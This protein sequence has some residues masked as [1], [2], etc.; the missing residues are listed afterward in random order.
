[1]KHQKEFCIIGPSY[2]FRGGIPHY[3]TLLYKNLKKRHSVSFYAFKR[4]YPKWLFPGK[5]DRD[6]SSIAIKDDSIENMLD[7][8]NP[9]TWLKAFQKVKQDDPNVLIFP[10]WVSFWTPQFWSISTLI[11]KFTSAKVLFICHNIVQHE[12]KLWDRLC[13]KLVLKNGDYFIVHSDEDLGNLKNILPEANVKKTFHPTYEVF[14][15]R[16]GE[17][18]LAHTKSEAQ[19]QLGVSGRVMLFFGFVRPYKGLKYLLDAMP[20]V[21]ERFDVTLLVV[22]EFWHDKADYL[23][24]I[25]RLG[26]KDKVMIVDRYVPNEEVSV[27]FCA[28]DVLVLPYVTAT[29]SGIVQIAYGFNKPVIVTRVGGLPDV[30]E[31]GKTG[32]LVEPEN[33]Q[34]IAKA[35]ISFY[36]GEW[37]DRFVRNISEE[38]EKFSWNRMIE[39]I[40]SF[41]E[42]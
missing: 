30:V 35:V 13:T 38:R 41:W 7:S 39:V 12:S 20:I 3:T 28:A 6:P 4:Q 11:R 34:A 2:P 42:S 24:Q 14:N 31:H 27:Y 9:L 8:I 19:R 5:T 15:F 17:A 22:G 40:D 33:P 37:N 29:Q 36:E 10:W 18:C 23:K 21:L 16:M 32:F 26:I 25:D 1:L